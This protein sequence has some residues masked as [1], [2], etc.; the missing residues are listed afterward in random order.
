MGHER[1]SMRQGSRYTREGV[2]VTLAQTVYRSLNIE[3]KELVKR[4]VG[5]NELDLTLD[6]RNSE[7]E[8]SSW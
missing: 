7:K 3:K 1:P 8:K 6:T 2:D 4:A 5:K